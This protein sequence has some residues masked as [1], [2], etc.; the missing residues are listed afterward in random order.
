MNKFVFVFLSML[1]AVFLL[2][3][4]NKKQ[5][6]TSS[7]KL[8]IISLAPDITE[9]IYFI[10]EGD[11]IVANTRYCNY[12]FKAKS[13]AKIGGIIDIDI[14]KIITLKPTIV[15]ASYSG[16]PK[17]K[18]ERLQAL[19]V[20][21]ITIKSI[22][23]SDIIGNIAIIGG[24]IGKDTSVYQKDLKAKL[25]RVVC[26]T[27]NKSKKSSL[28][29][30]SVSPFYTVSTNTFISDALSRA[31]YSNIINSS[32]PYPMLDKERILS[33]KPEY[34]IVPSSLSNSTVSL[35]KLFAHLTKQPQYITVDNDSISRPGPRVFDVMVELAEGE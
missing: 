3:S 14:E 9:M 29:I 25:A 13:I 16:N 35:K 10:G 28:F 12:P 4:C 26:I 6:T 31:G 1:I 30:V 15:F 7:D 19:G 22:S 11:N 33:L 27:T 23:V 21:V 18:V 8:R 20:K 34:I 5:A 32:V 2:P 24:H 17:D